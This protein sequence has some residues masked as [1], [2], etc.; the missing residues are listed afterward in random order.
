M[1]SESGRLARIHD[2]CPRRKG[3][4]ARWSEHDDVWLPSVTHGGVVNVRPSSAQELTVDHIAAGHT[5]PILAKLTYFRA[6]PADALTRP[7]RTSWSLGWVK[8]SP[9][10]M[11]RPCLQREVHLMIELCT[12]IESG[13]EL[14]WTS[15]D[16]LMLAFARHPGFRTQWNHR[17]RCSVRPGSTTS[18]A[19]RPTGGTIHNVGVSSTL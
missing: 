10:P 16:I 1:V 15:I 17:S 9:L 12:A 2:V 6:H 18:C 13:Q 14:D 19:R 7:R 4:L 8:R 11:A 3:V 5:S